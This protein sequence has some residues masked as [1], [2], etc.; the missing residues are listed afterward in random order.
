MIAVGAA[1]TLV[2]TGAGKWFFA[3]FDAVVPVS[4][5]PERLRTALSVKANRSLF[6]T[7]LLLLWLI[8]LIVYFALDKSPITRLSILSGATLA[9]V[10]FFI[11]LIFVW[12]LE[13]VRRERRRAKAAEGATSSRL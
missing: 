6:G 8:G 13:A 12:E 9:F 1:L 11:F 5:A 4:N 2:I 7:A 10:S 3:I